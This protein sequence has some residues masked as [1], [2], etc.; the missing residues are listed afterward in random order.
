VNQ[1]KRKHSIF[2][3]KTNNLGQ[4]D[5]NKEACVVLPARIGTT[6]STMNTTVTNS[7]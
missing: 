2:K 4:V 3:K 6:L 5:A 1:R 7:K